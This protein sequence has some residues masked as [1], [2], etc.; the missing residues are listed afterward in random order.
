[1]SDTSGSRQYVLFRVGS[2]EYGL[3]IARVSSII[4]Y[5]PSTPVPRAPVTVEGVINLRGR[6]IPVVDVGKRLFDRTLEPSSSSRIIVAE[7]EGGVVGLAVDSA[8]EV[9]TVDLASIMPAPETALSSET[10]DAFEGVVEYADRLV[11]LLDLDKA[12]PR[13]AYEAA[14]GDLAEGDEDV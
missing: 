11:I 5:E 12:L 10:A 8:S 6:V 14:A 1:M 2:E 3:P 13:T 7:G 4:R 9:A